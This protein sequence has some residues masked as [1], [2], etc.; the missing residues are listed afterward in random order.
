MPRLVKSVVDRS[1]IG[2]GCPKNGIYLVV[3]KEIKN[4]INKNR[5]HT[6]YITNMSSCAQR[7]TYASK[8]EKVSGTPQVKS[9]ENRDKPGNS[10]GFTR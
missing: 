10:I 3:F 1:S 8:I 4:L 6:V 7:D 2:H 5:F 9:P